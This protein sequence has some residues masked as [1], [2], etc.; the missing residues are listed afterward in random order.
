MHPLL[1]RAKALLLLLVH[2]AAGATVADRAWGS[3]DGRV[4][5]RSDVG[6][7]YKMKSYAPDIATFR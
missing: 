6:L 4:A 7:P 3:R 1:E 5:L 2:V